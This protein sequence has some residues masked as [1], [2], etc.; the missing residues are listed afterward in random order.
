M[1]FSFLESIYVCIYILTGKTVDQ[2]K[3]Q[4]LDERVE[5]VIKKMEGFVDCDDEIRNELEKE[6]EVVKKNR[7]RKIVIG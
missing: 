5:K 6:M 3:L 2:V 1:C 4:E 7:R